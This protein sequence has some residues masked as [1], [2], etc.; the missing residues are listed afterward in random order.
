MELDLKNDEEQLVQLKAL[1]LTY[2]TYVRLV[3]H[4]I[5]KFEAEMK[6]AEARLA[7]ANKGIDQVCAPTPPSISLNSLY[8]KLIS[9]HCGG[10]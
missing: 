8:L 1:Q 4:E 9:A 3:K 10:Q 7:E 5:P 2:D 6:A